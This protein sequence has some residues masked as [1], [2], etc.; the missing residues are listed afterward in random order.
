MS[1]KRLFALAIVCSWLAGCGGSNENE[2][3][4][5]PG[6]LLLVNNSRDVSVVETTVYERTNT[7]FNPNL[8]LVPTP[9]PD[10]PYYDNYADITTDGQ[11]DYCDQSIL[12]INPA[13]TVRVSFI[14]STYDP[15]PSPIPGWVWSSRFMTIPMR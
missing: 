8:E 2:K 10:V 12:V 14:N 1:S 6:V 5:D 13:I 4:T 15:L 11:D 7:N 3:G 9:P